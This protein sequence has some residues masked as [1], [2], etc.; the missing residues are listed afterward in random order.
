[1]LSTL[2]TPALSGAVVSVVTFWASSISSLVCA[3]IVSNSCG[4]VRSTARRA[5]TQIYPQQFLAVFEGSVGI[6][7]GELDDL[8]QELRRETTTGS[9][10]APLQS[11]GPRGRA[12]GQGEA[13]TVTTSIAAERTQWAARISGGVAKDPGQHP[14]RPGGFWS[15]RRPRSTMV[16]GADGHCASIA[17]PAF[18]LSITRTDIDGATPPRRL[19][20]H[21]TGRNRG[22]KKRTH[23]PD[24]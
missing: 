23:R 3:I 9:R 7:T 20:D 16:D 4:H 19:Q 18:N 22:R 17:F 12:G 21:H 15:K 24:A 14:S 11:G 1:V 6:G 10:T 5:P 8:A 13:V 2:A